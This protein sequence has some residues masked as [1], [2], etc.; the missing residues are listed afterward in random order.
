M[1][2]VNRYITQTHNTAGSW[3]GV[4]TH[5][6]KQMHVTAK[7]YIHLCAET[8]KQRIYDIYTMYSS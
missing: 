3:G 6:H 2:R 1:I 7:Q 4:R 5:Q 8:E